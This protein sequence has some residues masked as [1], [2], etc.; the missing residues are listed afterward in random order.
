MMRRGVDLDALVS[1]DGVLDRIIHVMR[2]LCHRLPPE[3]LF[4]SPRVL[5]EYVA[6]P[7]SLPLFLDLGDWCNP[8]LGAI[9]KPSDSPCLRSLAGAL[10]SNRP[11]EYSCP[12]ELVNTHWSR[13][14]RWLGAATKVAP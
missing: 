12:R 7:P 1:G 6:R 4:Y 5:L 8:G 13:W 11:E 2:V 10:A 14:P 9:D 3:N